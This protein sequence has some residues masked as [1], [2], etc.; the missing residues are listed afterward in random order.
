MEG[1]TSAH[2]ENTDSI[3]RNWHPNRNYLRAR[4]EYGSCMCRVSFRGELPPRTR[5]IQVVIAI[6]IVFHGTTSAHAEN[7]LATS[8]GCGSH[9]NYLR[10]RGEYR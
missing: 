6:T 2:A 5:R 8:T 1:T 10:A 3:V 4:G 9:G 7:T